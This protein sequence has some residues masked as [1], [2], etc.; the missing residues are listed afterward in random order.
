MER[1]CAKLMRKN[2][3]LTMVPHRRGSIVD[4]RGYQV[5]SQE[6]VDAYGDTGDCGQNINLLRPALKKENC[7]CRTDLCNDKLS[8][9]VK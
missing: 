1:G 3:K 6:V 2:K 7:P 9:C 5:L 4:L 8:T